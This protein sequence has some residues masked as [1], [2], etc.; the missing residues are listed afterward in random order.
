M[1]FA[2]GGD[3]A[4]LVEERAGTWSYQLSG[5]QCLQGRGPLSP[6]IAANREVAS[7]RIAGFSIPIWAAMVTMRSSR[8]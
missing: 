5:R 1:A 7:P 3:A 6:R 2:D 8:M 4:G